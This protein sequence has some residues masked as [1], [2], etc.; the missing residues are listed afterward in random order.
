NIT[1]QK[2]FTVV[3]NGKLKKKIAKDGNFIW[4][5]KMKKPMSSYLVM[6]AIGHFEKECTKSS[7]KIPLEMYYEKEDANRVE[8]TYRHSKKIFDFFEKEIGVKY[9]WK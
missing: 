3:S 1:F 7:S 4:K 9:P 5:Y 6:L 2:S 8:P